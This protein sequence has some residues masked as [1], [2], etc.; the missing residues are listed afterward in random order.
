MPT[1]NST[2]TDY[3]SRKEIIG[4]MS[5]YNLAL[6]FNRKKAREIR[7]KAAEKIHLFAERHLHIN[8]KD[9]ELM[10]AYL[11]TFGYTGHRKVTKDTID[12]FDHLNATADYEC[13]SFFKRLQ[14]KPFHWGSYWSRNIARLFNRYD[15]I[16]YQQPA[17]TPIFEPAS[18]TTVSSKTLDAPTIQSTQQNNPVLVERTLGISHK[19][20][21]QKARALRK[22]QLK[23]REKKLLA[24]QKA[25]KERARN[26]KKI[27][28]PAPSAPVRHPQPRKKSFLNRYRDY[29]IYGLAFLGGMAGISS[30]AYM[31]ASQKK[32]QKTA[33]P[34]ENIIPVVQQNN[35]VKPITL[36]APD[37]V[38][39]NYYDSALKIHLGETKRDAL[40]DSLRNMAIT[41]KFSIPEGESIEHLAHVITVSDLVQPN[42]STNS[43]L[44]ECLHSETELSG[45]AQNKLWHIVQNA[46]DRAQ[47]IKGTATHSNFDHQTPQVQQAHLTA[48]NNLRR[49]GR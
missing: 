3:I 13:P 11:K 17:A 48:L 12:A 6:L 19:E 40:Y 37:A 23:E 33:K 39:K 1:K 29:F 2:N 49:A 44:Q 34:T 32:S 38:H 8:H 43:F 42:S 20:R 27:I 28:L 45:A 36:P 5:R 18:E 22:K 47:N 46:G 7:Q 41:Q 24:R 4:E 16:K 21:R 14:A 15:V 31:L 30:G 26:K 35:T 10:Y 25:E 9:C